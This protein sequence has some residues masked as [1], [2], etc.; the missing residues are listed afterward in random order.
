MNRIEINW[1]MPVLLLFFLFSTLFPTFINAQTLHQLRGSLTDPQGAALSG[2]T[3]TLYERSGRSQLSMIT[4]AKGEYYFNRVAAGDYIAEF[5]AAGFVKATRE[6]RITTSSGVDEILNV[7]LDVA[8]VSADVVVTASGTIQPVDEVAKAITVIGAKQIEQRDELS[9]A[10]AVQTTPGLQV[11]QLGGPGTFT[12]ILTRGLRSS[13]TAVL[14]DGLR[15][16]DS[17]DISGSAQPFLSD[18]LFVDADRIEVLRGSGSSLYGTNAIAG[19]INVVTDQGGGEPHG[20]IQLE[21]G[22]LGFFRGRGQISG[23]AIDNRLF[24]SGG[25]AHLNVARGV[26]GDDATRNTSGQG[27][28][29]YNFTPS[30]SLSGRLLASKAFV[31]LNEDPLLAPGFSPAPGESLIHAVPLD[32]DEEE[33]LERLAITPATGNYT[34]GDANFIADLND[35][36]NRRN[37][38]FFTGALVFTQ[39]INDGISY[40]VS[41][42]RVDTRL[43]FRDGP[44]GISS[45][46]E[47]LFTT[48]NAFDGGIDTIN[49]RADL[50]LGRFNALSTGYEFERETFFNRSRD[51][52]P[53]PLLR[54]DGSVGIKQRSHAFFVQDQMR[55]L[56]NR[57]Q[58]SAA[59]RVQGFHIS[60]PEIKG[61]FFPITDI[62]IESPPTA[63]T[64]D[65]SI[66][67][68]FRATGTKLRAHIGNGYRAPSLVNRFG[69][70]FFGSFLSISGDPRLRPERSI[71][72]DGGI[73]QELLRDRVRLSATY[74]YTRL[75][76]VIEFGA[77][78][79]TDPFGRTFGYFNN[80]GGIARGVEL[81]A[82]INPTR[83]LDLFTSYTYTNSVNTRDTIPGFIRVPVISKH[84]FTV[85]ANQRIRDRIDVTFDLSAAS[86]YSP[87]FPTPS[88]DTL[89]V[90]DGP[91][92]GDLGVSYTLPVNEKRRV[93]F[94]VKVENIFNRDNFI[95]GFRTPKAQAIG[96]A[97]FHF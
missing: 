69:A 21:G 27:L 80:N 47:P 42:Q 60:Q 29:G 67:Y 2:A 36:D 24:Y 78:P 77:L 22:G 57:L 23:G 28:I 48:D 51:E 3:V 49:V 91:I 93:R 72:I 63:Y 32:L 92:K 83:T 66:S 59:F 70:N 65:G 54:A 76:E 87:T 68:F 55:L 64:G 82:Q 46:G 45:F 18:L 84:L 73:D 71:A 8:G 62:A 9:I 40:R 5:S 15:L 97:T 35:P 53:D 94:Y 30:I 10:A 74:F 17:S 38:H 61:G 96:G 95:D 16:R 1:R 12:R 52:N 58:V 89:Y 7:S 50:N 88:F 6:V 43:V 37:S 56:E 33:R 79:P 14:I 31:Q 81:S 90:F 20:D 41:Y 26:D 19:V 86:E 13:D 44:A 39:K 4:D 34:R 75:Q 25:I 85:V 11:G